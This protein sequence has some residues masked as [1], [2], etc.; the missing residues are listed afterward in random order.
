MY[1]DGCPA[2]LT[3]KETISLNVV[4][5]TGSS[6]LAGRFMP[7][8]EKVAR[9]MREYSSVNGVISGHTDSTGS[10]EYNRGLSQRRAETVR[11]ILL[12]EFGINPGRLNAIGYGEDRPIASNETNEGRQQNRRVE[13]V[14]EAEIT[15]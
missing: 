8:I 4:F 6:Q 5:D 14:F 11:T 2:R 12:N 9:F 13:A 1:A 15:E 3:R 7:E 10:A